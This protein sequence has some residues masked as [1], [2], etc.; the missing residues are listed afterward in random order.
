M[1]FFFFI[2]FLFVS[3]SW[4][5]EPPPSQYQVSV[6]LLGA[7]GL[8]SVFGSHR[9]LESFAANAGVSFYR[10]DAKTE[11]Q[12]DVAVN[13]L[14]LPLSVSYLFQNL[15]IEALAG[16][17]FVFSSGEIKGRGVN[18][19]LTQNTFVPQVGGG[20]R[21]WPV[22]GGFHFRATL[23]GVLSTRFYPWLG[24]SFGWAF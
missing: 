5:K 7:G 16:I 2:F 19:E 17:N 24:T 18:L 21:L 6:E 3:P 22:E 13:L 12:A 23:Y 11:N 14:Q 15:P 4:A 9:F 20:Y 10:I 1:R 8:Y